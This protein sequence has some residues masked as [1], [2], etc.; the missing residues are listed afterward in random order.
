M[1]TVSCFGM[2]NYGQSLLALLCYTLNVAGKNPA[3]TVAPKSEQYFINFK[4]RDMSTE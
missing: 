1:E 4:Q 3:K 2:R